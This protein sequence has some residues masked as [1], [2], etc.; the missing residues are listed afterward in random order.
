MNRKSFTQQ[1]KTKSFIPPVRGILQRK[2][3]CGNHIPA[4][5]EYSQCSKS[6]GTGLLRSAVSNQQGH[7][8]SPVSNFVPAI[9]QTKLTVSKPGDKYEQEAD[10]VADAVMRIPESQVQSKGCLSCSDIENDEQIQAK[11]IAGRITPLAQ[12]EVEEE[13]MIRTKSI[14]SYQ[15]ILQ[16][17]KVPEEETETTSF[18]PLLEE[19]ISTVEV[20]PE[21]EEED[22][23]VLLS[24]MEGPR[25]SPESGIADRIARAHSGGRTLSNSAQSFMAPRFGYD[26]SKVR[27]HTDDRADQLSKE[28]GAA[29]F[30]IG[31]NVFFRSGR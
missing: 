14:S 19:V 17:Q 12:R 18:E 10:R 30:T 16:R 7:G 5:K 1:T 25:G 3:S 21:G 24:R 26:F 27:V 8:L 20:H 28:L 13:E 23:T 15:D 29:A 4:G 2:C 6:V 9:I 11:P 22:G 31:N